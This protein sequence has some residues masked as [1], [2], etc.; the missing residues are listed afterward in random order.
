MRASTAWPAVGAL[1]DNA[2]LRR[3]PTLI[4]L[5]GLEMPDV[6]PEDASGVALC[7][8]GSSL[9]PVLTAPSTTKDWRP[10]AFMQYPHCMH[11]E[12][13]WVRAAAPVPS[14]SEF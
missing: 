5:A 6:C 8:E 12:R 7:R 13:I 9:R 4:D 10:A 2:V 11:D 3:M 14:S 1:S